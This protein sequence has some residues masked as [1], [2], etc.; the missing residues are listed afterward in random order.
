MKLDSRRLWPVFAAS[1]VF[2]A[3]CASAA[4][5]RAAPLADYGE[6]RW[7]FGGDLGCSVV[8]G[9]AKEHVFSPKSAWLEYSKETGAPPEKS[10]HQFSRLD[11]DL[12][13][14]MVG[15]SGSIRRNRFSLNAGVWYGGSG[16]DDLEM[17]DY[18]W[19][20]GD[21]A[22]HSH[23]SRS[24]TELTDAWLFDANLSFDFF[25]GG[26]SA[27]YVFAGAREQR[28]KWT[29]DGRADLWYPDNGYV[30]VRTHGHDIDYRQVLFFGY[31]GIGGKWKLADNLNLDAYFSFAPGYK[32]RDRDNHVTSEKYFID[33]FDYDDGAV[34]GAGVSVEWRLSDSM[35]L[36]CALDWQKATLHEGDL[37]VENLED[38]SIETE[39]DA[40]G[41]ENGYVAASFSGTY[42]F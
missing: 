26:D 2:S 21:K 40:A 17:D 23:H 3:V 19:L 28:W 39:D 10:R 14:S 31:F 12:V 30:R 42:R 32:G 4:G 29:C 9:C 8:A 38:G 1:A 11:W 16:S 22:R 7:T 41:I 15:A 13:A 35:S 36:V 6:D 34:Y 20:Y 18:D 33:S 5:F 24:E 25:R 37:R 27:G